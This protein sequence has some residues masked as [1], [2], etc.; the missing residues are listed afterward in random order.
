MTSNYIPKCEMIQVPR[1]VQQYIC[2]LSISKPQ[3]WPCY[4]SVEKALDKIDT[5]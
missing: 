3:N 2:G 5:F 4:K 1:W